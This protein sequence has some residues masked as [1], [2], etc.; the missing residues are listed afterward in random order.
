MVQAAERLVAYCQETGTVP[1]TAVP[2]ERSVAFELHP[3]PARKA[4]S[5]ATSRSWALRTHYR[6]AEACGQARILPWEGFRVVVL[7]GDAGSLIDSDRC[8]GLAQCLGALA[9]TLKKRSIV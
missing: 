2:R 6:T 5:R 9:R 7:F 8:P 1:K 3:D 4:R